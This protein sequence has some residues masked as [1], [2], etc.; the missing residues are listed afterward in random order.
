MI[1]SGGRGV[2]RDAIIAAGQLDESDG[3]D[4]VD[5]MVAQVRRKTGVRGRGNAYA[6]SGS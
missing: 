4:T 6:R 2:T 5:A 1:T 3:P